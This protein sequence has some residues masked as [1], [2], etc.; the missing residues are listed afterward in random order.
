MSVIV[1]LSFCSCDVSSRHQ[2]KKR[3]KTKITEIIS[4]QRTE[5]K[6]IEQSSCAVTEDKYYCF[7]MGTMVQEWWVHPDGST[8]VRVRMSCYSC[9]GQNVCNICQ[10]TG[11]GYNMLAG[12]GR[13]MP[14]PA[15][16]ATGQCG[17]C[18]GAGYVETVKRWQPGEAEA[19]LSAHKEVEREYL[20]QGGSYHRN[21]QERHRG[22]RVKEY[23]P[24][25][26]GKAVQTW[27]EECHDYDYP[28]YHRWKY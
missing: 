17:T 5:E 15:C 23:S 27:C 10:G 1:L 2:I 4:K 24:D 22:T 20:N 14:C 18:H 3:K 13:Y 25:Y 6:N 8:T 9:K 11:N 19:Y 12:S 7:N 21:S 16:G 26:T 28:H